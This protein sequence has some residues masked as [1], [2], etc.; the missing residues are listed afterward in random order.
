MPDLQHTLLHALTPL[1]GHELLAQ[2]VAPLLVTSS[3]AKGFTK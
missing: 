3:G 2:Y 1:R